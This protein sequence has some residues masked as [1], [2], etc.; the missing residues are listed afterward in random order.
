MFEQNLFVVSLVWQV[1]CSIIM[2]VLR[3]MAGVI[4]HN[5]E[6]CMDVFILIIYTVRASELKYNIKTTT[7]FL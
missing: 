7:S 1:N 5:S 3:Y 2:K 4:S 6:T